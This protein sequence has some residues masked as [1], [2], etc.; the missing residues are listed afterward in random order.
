MIGYVGMVVDFWVSRVLILCVGG[1]L[2]WVFI[3]R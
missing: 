2:F 3:C 1:M